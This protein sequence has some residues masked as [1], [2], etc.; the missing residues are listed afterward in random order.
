MSARQDNQ[1]VAKEA[2][3]AITP[4]VG[5][6]HLNWQNWCKAVY[7][8]EMLDLMWKKEKGHALKFVIHD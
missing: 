7:Y 4:G 5:D 8:V 6:A 2:Q 1:N 3:Q